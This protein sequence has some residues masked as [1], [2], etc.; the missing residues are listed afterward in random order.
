[1]ACPSSFLIPERMGGEIHFCI[2]HYIALV[3]Y[4]GQDFKALTLISF[5][6]FKSFSKI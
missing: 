5:F 3:R 2:D 1:V 6:G 4:H